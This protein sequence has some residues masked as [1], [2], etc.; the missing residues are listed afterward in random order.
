MLGL[1]IITAGGSGWSAEQEEMIPDE[2]DHLTLM[3]LRWCIF[4]NARLDGESDEVD[5]YAGWEVDGYNTR[6]NHYNNRCSDKSYYER[7]ESRVEREMTIGKRQILQKQG[8][9]RVRNARL[10][11][12][13]RRAYVNGEVA[14]V[15]SDPDDAGT[16]LGRVPR[17]GELIKTGRVQ[18]AWFEVEWQKPS[19]DNVLQ[20][21]WVLGG[22]LEGGRGEEARFKYCEEHAKKPRPMYNKPVRGKIDPTRKNSIEVENGTSEDAYVKLIDRYDRVV[23]S[24]LTEAGKTSLLKGIPDGSYGIAFATGSKFSSGCDSFSVRGYAQ[25]FDRKMDY[26]LH[27]AGWKLTLQTVSGGNARTSSMSYD[28]FDRL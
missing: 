6:I 10:E 27:T 19:L 17:W 5:A 20:F 4:E 23:L 12:E 7:D 26:D 16:E 11:R 18:G 9:L 8:A 13:A 25:M 21:G 24:F 1:A 28:D 15:L 2:N 14:R 22:L 3:E